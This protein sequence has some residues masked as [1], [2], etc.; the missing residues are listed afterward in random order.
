MHNIYIKLIQPPKFVTTV[1]WHLNGAFVY[2]VCSLDISLGHT[3]NRSV[4]HV[5]MWP[6]SVMKPG[7]L[8]H[9][10]VTSSLYCMSPTFNR[11]DLPPFSACNIENMEWV[12]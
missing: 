7:S 12:Y 10:H 1:G 2:G 9:D 4:V 6:A 11:P 8:S 5:C 3:H